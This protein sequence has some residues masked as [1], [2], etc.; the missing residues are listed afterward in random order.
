MQGLVCFAGAP[1]VGKTSTALAVQ[2]RLS[3]LG[4]HAGYAP[5]FARDL[6]ARYGYPEHAAFQL[7][8][9]Y[10]QR[11]AEEQALGGSG[12][13]V[14]DT[15]TWFCYL[16]PYLFNSPSAGEQERQVISDLYTISAYWHR[17]YAHTFYLPLRDDIEADGIRDPHAS[18]FI[19]DEM[20]QYLDDHQETLPDVTYVPEGLDL[21]QTVE[22]ALGAM[23]VVLPPVTFTPLPG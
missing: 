2:E 4:Q 21:A 20:R 10:Q 16:F 12:L 18:A 3:G 22:F 8:A 7:H 19:D 14:T 9:A 15:A 17:N 11:G 1:G 23:G 5:E 13:A 6:I